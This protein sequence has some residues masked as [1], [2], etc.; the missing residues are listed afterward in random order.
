M[1]CDI[2]AMIEKRHWYREE[3]RQEKFFYVNAGNPHILRNYPLFAFLAGVRNYY[4]INPISRP[5]GI[6]VYPED[7]PPGA[8]RCD[9]FYPDDLFFRMSHCLEYRLLAKFYGEDGHSHSWLSLA[10]MKGSDIR[11]EMSNAGIKDVLNLSLIWDDLIAVM[12]HYG[13]G[14]EDHEIRL[15]FFF[16]N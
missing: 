6:L 3:D 7:L 4:G 16:D 1:G 2:H 12:E 13:K 8:K 14:L 11:K 10:E 5:R 15:S 9:K